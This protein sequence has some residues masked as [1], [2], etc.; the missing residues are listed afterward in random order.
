MTQVK[1]NRLLKLL[2]FIYKQAGI[3]LTSIYHPV[4]VSHICVNWHTIPLISLNHLSVPY[5]LVPRP[6]PL[7]RKECG[8]TGCL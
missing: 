5:S 2:F 8:V 6:N 3:L 7:T 4:N 1:T